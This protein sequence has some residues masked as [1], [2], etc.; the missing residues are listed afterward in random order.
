MVTAEEREVPVEAA[1]DA[2]D[3]VRLEI[4]LR[5]NRLGAVKAAAY[6][7][8][9]RFSA[10]FGAVVDDQLEVELMFAPG[11]SS[12]AKTAAVRALLQQ[13][14][15]EELRERV[16]E[17]TAPIRALL[18]AQAFSRTDLIER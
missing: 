8:A 17:E 1:R 9:A 15:D 5:S 13:M 11:V 12:E 2:T 10:R 4:D 3:L 14:L 18:L 7:L 6:R 16:R